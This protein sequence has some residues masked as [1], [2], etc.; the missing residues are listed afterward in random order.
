VTLVVRRTCFGQPMKL[1]LKLRP[2]VG[3]PVCLGVELPGQPMFEFESYCNRRSVAQ[4]VLVSGPLWGRWPDFKFLWV[5]ITFFLHHVG[6]PLW[7]EDGSVMYSAI[8][9]WLESSRTHKH[10]LF[11]SA[12]LPTFRSSPLT[13]IPHEQGGPARSQSHVTT[14]S[15]SV[16]QYVF[17]SSPRL[18]IRH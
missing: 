5:T 10:V 1:K 6:R 2:T 18:K 11:S 4:F 3:R 14:D 8:T 13:H 9:Q 12:T 7:R 16:S 17:V 15:Q